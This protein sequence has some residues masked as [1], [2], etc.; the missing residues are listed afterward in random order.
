MLNNFA[1]AYAFAQEKD[2]SNPILTKEDEKMIALRKFYNKEITRE[3]F[4]AEWGHYALNAYEVESK[5][6]EEYTEHEL[7]KIAKLAIHIPVKK[8]ISYED[9]SEKRK[10]PVLLYLRELA[11][12]KILLLIKEIRKTTSL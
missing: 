6:F 7:M 1:L 11:K 10:V 8:K 4:N 12:Y 5:R 9:Y 3:E 2:V